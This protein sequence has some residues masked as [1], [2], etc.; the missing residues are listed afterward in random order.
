VLLTSAGDGDAYVAKT[1]RDGSFVWA[2]KI[3]GKNNEAGNAIAVDDASNVYFAGYVST[4]T[5]DLDPGAGTF[6][7]RIL[8][9]IAVFVVKLDDRGIFVW[10]GAMDGAGSTQGMAVD[11]EGGILISGGH[12]GTMYAD[13]N[14]P[15]WPLVASTGGLGDTFLV[16]WTQPVSTAAVATAAVSTTSTSKLEPLSPV[17]ESPLP[18]SKKLKNEDAA[19][20]VDAV[21]AQLT[22]SLKRSQVEDEELDDLSELNTFDLLLS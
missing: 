10:G 14:T 7:R 9:G 15:A 22:E 16:K 2:R 5:I 17:L 6:N 21:F 11:R 20:R 18:L 3:G 19:T 13:P 1:K 8:S 4:G 12:S